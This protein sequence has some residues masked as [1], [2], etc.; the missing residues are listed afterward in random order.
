M[1]TKKRK[2]IFRRVKKIWREN[3]GY[4]RGCLLKGWLRNRFEG[5]D[6]S[7]VACVILVFPGSL[8]PTK[9]L[10]PYPTVNQRAAYFETS[11]AARSPVT[12]TAQ[13]NVCARITGLGA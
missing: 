12:G 4:K 1:M 5:N 8:S 6:W 13:K 3:D 7:W 2:V 11:S 10:L 9:R